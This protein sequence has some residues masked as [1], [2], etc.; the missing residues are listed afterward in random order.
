MT[1]GPAAP[2]IRL[3]MRQVHPPTAEFAIDTSGF[4]TRE[5]SQAPAERFTCRLPDWT[6]VLTVPGFA[7]ASPGSS[8]HLAAHIPLNT[9]TTPP[10]LLPSQLPRTPPT[11]AHAP[12]PKNSPS[13]YQPTHALTMSGRAGGGGGRKVL[14]P[15]I[16]FIFKLLQ[17]HSTVQIWLYEQLGIRIEGKI[18]GFDEFM[19]L[20]IDDAVEVKQPTKAEPE[21]A[22]ARRE[23]GMYLVFLI[24]FLGLFFRFF[25]SW[26]R[27]G[28]YF[29][30]I[31]HYGWEKD[32]GGLRRA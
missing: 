18:R 10:I 28:G 19:N 7:I 3:P 22:D 27:V 11:L 2:P 16:N 14:L 13:T 31:R 32:Y 23:L 24:S 25:L 21:P 20:V 26:W 5:L 12:N 9:D 30:V 29:L 8:T 15:P 1:D 6:V 4:T 17:Q